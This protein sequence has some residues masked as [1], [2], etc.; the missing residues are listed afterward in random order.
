MLRNP[1]TA[2]AV[3]AVLVL[4]LFMF[5]QAVIAQD[6]EPS[7]PIHL[8]PYTIPERV[9]ADYNRQLEAV[10][11]RLDAIEAETLAQARA[12]PI[13]PGTRLH[14]IRTLGKLLLYDKNL[15]VGRNAPCTICHTQETGF[16]GPVSELN[17]TT[18]AYPGSVRYRFGSRKP[19]SYAYSPYGQIMHFDPGSQSL[20]GANFWDQRASGWKLQNPS[21]QQA[22]EPPVDPLEMGFSD[23]ACAVYRLSQ[24]QYLFLFENLWGSMIRD[25]RWP[26]DIGQIC[27][28]PTQG[29][30]DPDFPGNVQLDAI[31][32][33]IEKA[34]YDQLGMSITA[35]EAGPDVSPFNSKFDYAI[36]HPNE[37]VLTAS[38]LAGW[39]LFDGKGKCNLCHLDSLSAVQRDE[40]SVNPELVPETQPLFTDFQAFNIGVPKN[41]DIPFLYENT[42]DRF[43][44]TPNPQGPSFTDLGL[45]AFLA[46]QMGVG[47]INPNDAWKALI[48]RSDGKFQTATI[49][50]VDKR[51]YRGFVKAYFH[52]GFVKSL[53]E[54]VHFYN[55]RDVLP[56]CA[57]GDSA[58]VGKTC[59]PAPEVSENLDQRIG[60]LGLTEK[61]ENQIVEFMQTLTDGY[62]PINPNF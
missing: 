58:G 47:Q 19:K 8:G 34:V 40:P 1:A 53:K 10:L 3:A 48:S 45:G 23:S 4:S 62:F 56:R 46:D 25:I 15:S 57:S 21:S 11:Q 52:N 39:R 41:D 42:P 24:A 51:P 55:T 6:V 33:S 30:A 50:D 61:E 38:E 13:T 32:R 44:V 9:P 18:V 2:R 26:S 12:L 29:P 49:R 5:V 43:G 7:H 60:N 35:N 28:T 27:D 20:Y 37:P 54:V 16:T 14:R 31:S 22:Q 17:A 36:T 59:W